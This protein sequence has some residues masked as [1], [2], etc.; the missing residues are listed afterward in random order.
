MAK[1]LADIINAPKSAEV[2]LDKC[3]IVKQQEDGTYNIACEINGSKVYVNY[4]DTAK[5]SNNK[6]YVRFGKKEESWKKE[7]WYQVES[8]VET[9]T[10]E[11]E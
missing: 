2:D 11:E 5:C 10:K 4:V 7:R 1:T 9:E 6:L 3:F 8:P